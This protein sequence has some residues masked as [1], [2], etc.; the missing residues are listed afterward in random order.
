MTHTSQIAAAV[1]RTEERFGAVEVLLNNAGYSYQSSIEEG[2]DSETRAQFETN[3]FGP[4]A[5]TRA[6]LLGMRARR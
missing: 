1:K 5:I 3:V 6:V 4:A 2:I